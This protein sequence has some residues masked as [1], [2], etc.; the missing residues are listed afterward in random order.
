M[1]LG[2]ETY[3]SSLIEHVIV[4]ICGDIEQIQIMCLIQTEVFVDLAPWFVWF[5][6]GADIVLNGCSSL[7]VWHSAFKVEDVSLNCTERVIVANVET[8]CGGRLSRL[9]S[10]LDDLDVLSCHEVG[11]CSTFLSLLLRLD[12]LSSYGLCLIEVVLGGLFL[13]VDRRIT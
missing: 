6:F 5:L 1:I 7:G 10:L 11:I 13:F 9:R 2:V 12:L 8:C 4:H 3:L